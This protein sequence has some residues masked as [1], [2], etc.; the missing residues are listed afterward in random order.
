MGKASRD[1]GKRVELKFVKMAQKFR[2][3]AR[4]RQQYSGTDGSDDLAIKGLEF[5]HLES[6]GE[7][8]MRIQQWL[9]IAYEKGLRT[10]F[11]VILQDGGVRIKGT[12]RFKYPVAVMHAEDF[13]NMLAQLLG[14]SKKP[15][16]RG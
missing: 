11:P 14:G 9:D 2:F 13:F 3:N 6:K 1:K 10:Q 7:K 15:T 12:N 8:N 5:L 16:R 4:R